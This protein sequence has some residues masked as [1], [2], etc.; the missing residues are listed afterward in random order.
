MSVS[1]HVVLNQ[2]VL[3]QLHICQD[4]VKKEVGLRN[5]AVKQKALMSQMLHL[6]SEVNSHV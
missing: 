3:F 1:I 2:S 6:K 5:E 4:E